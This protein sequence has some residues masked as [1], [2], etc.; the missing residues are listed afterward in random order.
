MSRC[1]PARAI[2]PQAAVDLDEQTSSTVAFPAW[3][4]VLDLTLG[5]LA[6]IVMAPVMLVA[7]ALVRATSPGPAL[8]RQTR[9]GLGERPFRMLKFRSM[10]EGI[11]DPDQARAAIAG[12]LSGEAQPD[13]DGLYRAHDDRATAVGAFLRQTS[14]DELPQLF[15][16]L[17]G[18]M[19]LVGPRPAL[20][21]EVQMFTRSQRRRH[22]RPPGMTGLWQV[23]T[24]NRASTRD[25]LDV[26]LLY[27]EQCSL[28]LDLKIIARTPAA[29]LL[30]RNTR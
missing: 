7:A 27:V 29:V 24:R 9:I 12:E 23:T 11:T 26:D 3:K 6:L 30:H 17:K 20:P 2:E 14:I 4:R 16:V 28:L 19:S 10:R 1:D 15:N 8:F 22:S 21:W 18:E 25:M 13:A 5:G